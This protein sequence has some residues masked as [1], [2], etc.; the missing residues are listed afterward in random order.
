MISVRRDY[1]IRS[2]YDYE[3]TVRDKHDVLLIVDRDLGGI[4]VTNNIEK[5]VDR[6]ARENNIDPSGFKILYYDSDGIWDGWDYKTK[7]F[8][9]VGEKKLRKAV[10]KYVRG[11]VDPK[12]KING[13]T[14]SRH[15]EN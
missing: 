5:I 3:I 2:D 11:I 4:S 7:K 13:D 12:Q 1:Y 8:V 9:F 10:D 14:E 15:L 6:I